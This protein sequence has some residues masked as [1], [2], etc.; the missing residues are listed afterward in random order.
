MTKIIAGEVKTIKIMKDYV[1]NHHTG[2]FVRQTHARFLSL[3]I[4][5]QD[6]EHVTKAEREIL[7]VIET[8]LFERTSL[9]DVMLLTIEVHSLLIMT[10]PVASESAKMYN[11]I[12]LHDVIV[13][14]GIHLEANSTSFNQFLLSV[15]EI[16]RTIDNLLIATDQVFALRGADTTELVMKPIEVQNSEKIPANHERY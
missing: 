16:H 7:D 2:I 5:Y 11:L 12:E 8:L 9:A 3:S 1:S 10:N 4:E 14:L 15:D 6:C 13:K